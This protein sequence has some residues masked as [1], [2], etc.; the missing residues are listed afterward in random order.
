[1][2]AYAAGKLLRAVLVVFLVSILTFFVLELTPG[3]VATSILGMGA[4]PEAV[5]QL[6]QSLGL[7]RPAPERYAEWLW[8]LLSGNPG[9][10][11]LT[12]LPIAT[13]VFQA[14]FMTLQLVLLGTLLSFGFA[15]LFG[16][17]AAR[18]PRTL[19]DKT[20][21]GLTSLAIALPTFVIGPILAYALGVQLRWFP[22]ATYSP[23]SEG[24]GPWLRSIALP[25]FCLALTEF[26]TYQR[27]LRAD[28]IAVLHEPYIEAAR[29][30]GLSERRILVLHAMRPAA[31]P[32]LTAMGLSVGRL[33]GGTIIVENLFG[34]PG[35]G[36]TLST[37]ILARDLDVV[38]VA[39]VVVAGA[40]VFINT[41]IDLAYGLIDPRIRVREAAS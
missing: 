1:M 13:T 41:F 5:A 22:V 17:F 35:L 7:D 15:M 21:D 9:E 34:I 4:S 20:G 27:L 16:A 31:I 39:V 11:N 28:L 8:N 12:H 36:K 33:I 18:Y 30:R 3:T 40:F 26:A 38:L 37:A 32:A 29:A 6:E 19:I 2:L 10:S 23:I 25:V 14:T 24:V